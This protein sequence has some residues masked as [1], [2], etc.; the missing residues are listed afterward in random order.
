MLEGLAEFVNGGIVDLS[1]LNIF[2]PVLIIFLV[3]IAKRWNAIPLNPKNKNQIRTVVAALAVVFTVGDVVMSGGE[4]TR[5]SLG[6]LTGNSAIA[7]L[8]SHLGYGAVK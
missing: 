6:G 4:I 5:E 1:S 7:Y 2:I 3:G 8:L